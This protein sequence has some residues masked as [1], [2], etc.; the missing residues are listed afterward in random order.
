MGESIA[1]HVEDLNLCAGGLG[2]WPPTFRL[3]AM[4]TN[5][6]NSGNVKRCL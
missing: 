1:L 5:K 6:P 3:L 2:T 4:F